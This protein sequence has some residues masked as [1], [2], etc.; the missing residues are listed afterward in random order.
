MISLKRA[1]VVTAG[2]SGAGMM[3]GGVCAAT[4]VCIAVAFESGISALLSS[5]SLWNLLRIAATGAVIGGIAA[6]AYVWAVMRRVPLG[7]GAA[8]TALGTVVGAIVG[9]R[10]API[11][12]SGMSYTPGILCGALVGFVLA[13]VLARMVWGRSRASEFDEAAV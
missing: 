4:A 1:I 5:V 2:L 8:S 12:S 7:A 10:I 3:L 11:N 9:N 6:P 13:G